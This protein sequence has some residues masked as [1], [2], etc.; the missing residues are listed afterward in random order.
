MENALPNV[1]LKYSLKISQSKN[2]FLF[3][4][5]FKR[6]SPLKSKETPLLF[7]YVFYDTL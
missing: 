7:D 5:M 3:K 6:L 2:S 4:E 1:F